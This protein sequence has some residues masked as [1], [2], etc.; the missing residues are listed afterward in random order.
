MK[1]IQETLQKYLFPIAMK[2]EKQKHLQSVKDG[3]IAIV[4]III[5]G[6]FCLIP[7]GI[8]NLIGGGAAQWVEAH[9]DIFNFPTYFTTNLMSL[10]SAFFIADSLAKRY[11]MKSSLIGISSVLVQLILCVSIKE[12]AWDVSSLGAEGL[13]VSIIAAI[14]V[15]EVT[16][17]MDKYHLTIRMPASVPP[18]VAESFSILIPLAVNVV[19][20]CTVALCIVDVTGMTFPKMI[21]SLLAPAISSMDS[22]PAVILVV[23]FTQL[24]WVFGL[25]GAA[26]TSSVW[27]PF[28]IA[29]ATENAAAVAAGTMPTHIF[30]FGFYYG[31]LQ[32]SGS[33]LT[34]CLVLMMC[35]SK[36]KS[37]KSIG[38]IGLV[39]SLF[40]INE[41]IIFGVP[42]IMNPFMFIP[43]VFGPVIIA[44]I[45][46]TSMSTGLVALPLG[47]AP[48]FLP[49]GFQAFLL[50]MDWK[51]A[52]LAVGSVLLMG[53]FYYP[54][55]KMMEA[56]EIRKEN[57]IEQK[58]E[59]TK[60]G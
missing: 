20:A 21:M 12:G 14:F 3:V 8:G 1:K 50:T 51:A 2:L 59:A 37:L 27:A 17:L 26:I 58:A 48:G 30:T 24:L 35:R 15:V 42:M 43:F 29:Y 23:L 18:M 6:S 54:F 34:L 9:M 32:V 55:F 13:F 31:F 16:R 45:A 28:A 52:V 11:N 40:G 39:P 46:Y 10:F 38:K 7:V 56:D 47:E 49:P 44:I 22:L 5:I 25:H 19:V 36:A 53:V 41:P 33:G 60:E 57:E 4:P